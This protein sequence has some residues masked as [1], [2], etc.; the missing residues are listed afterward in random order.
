MK[1]VIITFFMGVVFSFSATVFAE[2]AKS[3]IGRAIEGQFPVKVNGQ[4]LDVPAIVIDGTSFLPVRAI[5]EALGLEVKFDADMGIELSE[6]KEVPTEMSEEDDAAIQRAEQQII[7]LTQRIAENNSNIETWEIEKIDIEEKLIQTTDK[8]Q[9][10]FLEHQIKMLQAN[11]D[12]AKEVNEDLR[13][14]INQLQEYI[15]KIRAKYMEE[16]S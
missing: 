11:I 15:Q 12:T 1:K 3:M 4:Q 5:G 10:V 2:E 6:R 8:D 7:Q 16:I 14:A 9:K 13:N